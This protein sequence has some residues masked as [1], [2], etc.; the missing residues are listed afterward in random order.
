MILSKSRKD[1]L[2]EQLRYFQNLMRDSDCRITVAERIAI[3]NLQMTIC[4]VLCIDA[5]TSGQYLK[6]LRGA[7]RTEYKFNKEE[8]HE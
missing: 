6:D 8:Q 5:K 3:R 7:P 1:K 2:R 4:D